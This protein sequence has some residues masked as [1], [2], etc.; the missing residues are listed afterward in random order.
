[1]KRLGLLPLLLALAAVSAPAALDL[2]LLSRDDP[3]GKAYSSIVLRG[4]S[5]SGALV[6]VA[7]TRG[8]DE[9][10]CDVNFQWK[11]SVLAARGEGKTETWKL[12]AS[13]N[14]GFG[15]KPIAGPVTEERKKNGCEKPAAAAEEYD[16]SPAGGEQQ[17]AALGKLTPTC[18]LDAGPCKSSS[19]RVLKLVTRT[20][21][22]DG[23][24]CRQ[25]RFALELD[26]K[27]LWQ[28]GGKDCA[29]ERSVLAAASWS[30]DGKRVAVGWTV[31]RSDQGYD[32]TVMYG[33]L[34]VFALPEGKPR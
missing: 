34:D 17:L 28:E 8:D 2:P 1:M 15:E 31:S 9:P 25:E 13:G 20:G 26:G 24:G 30:P 19:G 5:P 7:E 10:L 11:V 16:R 29:R 21:K 4:W 3:R 12:G 18:M 32:T 33:R 22:D 23:D 14:D 6:Y 27:S